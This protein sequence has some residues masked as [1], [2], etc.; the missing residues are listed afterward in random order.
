MDIVKLVCDVQTAFGNLK[1]DP[2][3]LAENI[4]KIS[5]EMHGV[6][7]ELEE[8]RDAIAKGDTDG[9]RDGLCDIL[10]FAIAALH[11]LGVDIHE[12]MTSVCEALMTRFVRGEKELL[13]TRAKYDALNV[14]YNVEGSFPL[15]VIRSAYDQQ[16]PEYPKGKFLKSAGFRQPSFRQYTAP[17]AAPGPLETLL[18]M[19]QPTPPNPPPLP[20][21]V[22]R[23]ILTPEVLSAKQVLDEMAAQRAATLELERRWVEYRAKLIDA[24]TTIIDGL[25]NERKKGLMDDTM[26]LKIGPITAKGS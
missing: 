26:Q 1:G 13:A 4:N 9:V 8:T 23:S 10:V 15:V 17:I 5:N 14:A 12:D 16:M 25:D 3:K 2:F 24:F 11:K 19:S 7:A 6:E 20:E 22:P 18:T 21:G